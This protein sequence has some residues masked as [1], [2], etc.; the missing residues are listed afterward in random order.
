I[1][2]DD[3]HLNSYLYAYGKMHR[4]KLFEAFSQIKKNI[5]E[6]AAT[7]FELYDWGCGQ[8]TATICLLD[9]LKENNLCP[10]IRRITLIDPSTVAVNRAE[11]VIKCYD[12]IKDVEIRKVCYLFDDLNEPNISGK[13]PKKLHL[14]SN[15]L[16]VVSFDLPNFINLFQQTI[17]NDNLFI[18]VG[19][20]YSNNERVDEFIAAI[21]PDVV[22][23]TMDKN[24]G[25]WKGDWTISLRI[26]HKEFKIKESAD[27][28]RQRIDEAKKSQ[29]FYAGYILDEVSD[30]LKKSMKA[31][32]ADILFRSLSS[33]D[34]TSNKTFR[35]PDEIDSKWAV[36]NNILTRGIP[37]IAPISIQE[38]FSKSFGTSKSLEIDSPSIHY[39]PKRE[40]DFLSLY[41]ALHIIEPRFEIKNY[42]EDLLGSGFEKSFIKRTLWDSPNKY[43]IQLLEPQRQL[44]TIVSLPNQKFTKDQRVDFAL[45]LP[46]N[47]DGGN[48][49]GFVVEIDGASYH[50]NIFARHKDERRDLFTANNNWN[51]CRLTENKDAAF[52]NNWINE[53]TCVEYLRLVKENY[54]KKISGEWSEYLQ[55][56]LS[57]LA[58]ARVEKVII[59]AVITGNLDITKKYN[60]AVIERDVPCA[61]MAVNNLFDCYEHLCYLA[62]TA[63]KRP[64]ISLQVQSTKEFISSP[65][66]RGYNV[67]EKLPN[68]K[69]DIC[70]DISMLLRDNIDTMGI[71]VD[72]ETYY[73]VRSSHYKKQER[74]IYTSKNIEYKPLVRKDT[75]GK[76]IDIE[77]QKEV[78]TYFLQNI[79]RKRALRNGQL[80][81]LSRTLSNKT[82]IGLLPTGGGKSLTYQLS[83][84][85]Q[86]GVTIVVDPLISLMVDQYRGLRD[87]RIDASAYLNS[88]MDATEKNRN[89]VQMQNGEVI[90]MLL[91]PE[92]FMMRNFRDSLLT[93]SRRNHVYFS[94]GVIDEVHC[95]SE[96]GHDF[97]PSYLHLG[98]NMIN[99]MET[100]LH[101]EDDKNDVP[102]NYKYKV[103]II[104]LTA[105]ASFDVLADVERE[106]TLGGDLKLDSEVIIRPED[107]ERPELTYKII[108]VK[109]NFSILY[110]ESHPYILNI[111]N[112]RPIKKIVSQ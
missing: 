39:S 53:N 108:E 86:P 85:L 28:I 30:V 49:T 103:S 102:D 47:K 97:R 112:D 62:G 48:P 63:I 51:T 77:E 95:V 101:S 75:S 10:K 9:Y 8:G 67:C 22:Y 65:L 69:Y 68:I 72:A 32:D 42:K 111:D 20:Y 87:I 5:E 91:S 40:L 96:W 59:E 71:N 110:D 3:N 90:F 17:T 29:Q 93:M 18:C 43:L 73:I 109:A 52:V 80:P 78:L 99:F 38:I 14:F 104:G 76:Y 15:I 37:T 107:D 12:F 58:I 56:V 34:V 88:T 36:V 81:I 26:F 25:C 54:G 6:I 4:E 1:L 16:D 83:S 106:L 50:S 66:H 105:T 19:P 45:E 7:D 92:R 21:S 79:F 46:T 23:A 89:L 57:P 24:K 27:N 94:Y 61:A 33:F 98:R 35:H 74:T 31:N 70:I 60:I 82:T 55:I 44:S 64:E 11:T 100:K 41:A 84:M 13:Y 2:E